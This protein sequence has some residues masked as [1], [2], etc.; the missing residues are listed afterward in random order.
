MLRL[1]AMAFVCMT[2]AV[3]FKISGIVMA[4]ANSDT[5]P[6]T[7]DTALDVRARRFGGHGP[8]PPSMIVLGTVASVSIRR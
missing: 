8:A 2:D 1:L 5:F 7:R 3:C 6:L 4:Q